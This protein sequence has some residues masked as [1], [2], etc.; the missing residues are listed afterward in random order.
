M[1]EVTVREFSRNPS[2]FFALAERGESVTVTKHGQPVA[3]VVPASG[4][5]GK[6]AKLVAEGKLRLAPY[7]GKDIEDFPRYKT[8]RPGSP[9]QT[10]LD[11][12]EEDAEREEEMHRLLGGK[13]ESDLSRRLR[14]HR[15]ECAEGPGR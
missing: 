6:Y 10:I 4:N 5:L 1:S 13:Q 8:D 11:M 14:S 3:V 15:L 9:M 12:R 7:T 2:A